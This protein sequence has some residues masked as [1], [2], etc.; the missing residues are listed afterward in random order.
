MISPKI[1][2][3]SEDIHHIRSSEWHNEPN[4]CDLGGAPMNTSRTTTRSQP[5]GATTPSTPDRRR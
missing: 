3:L 5:C 4:T 1:G 2:Q